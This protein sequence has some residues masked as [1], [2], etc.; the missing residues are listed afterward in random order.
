[1]W[2]LGRWRGLIGW[3]VMREIPEEWMVYFDRRSREDMMREFRAQVDGAPLSRSRGWRTCRGCG[4]HV[5]GSLC[6]LCGSDRVV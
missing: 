6:A 4:A 5:K 3:W 1:M 2:P